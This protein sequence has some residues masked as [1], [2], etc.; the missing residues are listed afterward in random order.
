MAPYVNFEEVPTYVALL[1]LGRIFVVFL[2]LGHTY[3]DF[4]DVCTNVNVGVAL[5][6]QITYVGHTK[7]AASK[8]LLNIYLLTIY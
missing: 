1:A 5:T 6:S 3:V 2:A 7:L 8:Y 4:N